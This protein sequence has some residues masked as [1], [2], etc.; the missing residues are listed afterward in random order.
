VVPPKIE[1]EPIKYPPYV[2]RIM[3][4]LNRQKEPEQTVKILH[5]KDTY[6]YFLFMLMSL[7]TESV[8]IRLQSPVRS[9]DKSLKDN[10]DSTPKLGPNNKDKP[11]FDTNKRDSSADTKTGTGESST[12]VPKERSTVHKKVDKYIYTLRTLIHI[13]THI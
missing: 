2:S 7:Y 9:C 3:R 10:V 11:S 12:R 1:T 4:I 6:S 13:V 8:N 5:I